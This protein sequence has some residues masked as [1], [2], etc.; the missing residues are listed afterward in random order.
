MSAAV[1]FTKK[2]LPQKEGLGEKLAKKRI[3]MGLDVKDVEKAIRIRWK[4]IEAIENSRY[5][6]LPPDVYVRGFIRNYAAYL[7][8]D[9][10][11]VMR[12]YLRERG[13]AENVKK[14]KA[15]A[16]VVKPIDTPK[17]LITPKTLTIGSVITASILIVVYIGWQVSILTAPPR[18]MVKSPKD[19][20][21]ITGN[22]TSVEGITDNGATVTINDV[23]V[24]IDQEGNF[25]ERISLTS[26]V[27]IIHIKAQ[28][29]LGKA[30]SQTR[31]IVAQTTND[32]N[33]ATE[34][35]FEVKL[36][37]GPRSASV[38]IEVDGKKVTDK[39]VVVV[40]GVTQTY[41]GKN[42]IKITTTDGG[43][44][45]ATY[46]GQNVGSLGKDGETVTREFVKDMK[47]Q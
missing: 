23:E 5:D 25:K 33:L 15:G 16:P 39:P 44:V 47:I 26:G 8:L 6:V 31:T 2:T 11:K 9:P 30:T 42:S 22:S 4:Y 7:K 43:T 18:L 40:A 14:A 3:A 29:K 21:N 27:N 24:G 20:V 36:S 12:L 1:K 34:G 41:K 19:N 17:L 37:I 46:N 28:N 10:E 13:L 35:S 45:S 38:S 32:T